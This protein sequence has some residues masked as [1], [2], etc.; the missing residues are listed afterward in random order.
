M[1]E[2]WAD[3]GA[4]AYLAAAAWAFFEGETFV[5]LASAAGHATGLIDPWILMVSVWIGS[6]LGDQL[7]FTL[8]QRYGMRAVRKIPGAEKRMAAALRFLDRY[9]TLFVLSFRFVYGVRNVASA[10]C[11][12]AG[13][14]RIRFAT[15]NFIAAGLWAASFVAAGW[16]LVAWLGERNTSYA[17]AGIGGAVV[18]YLI[19]RFIQHR[20][21]KA[22]AQ[23]Q[24]HGSPQAP[25]H[26]PAEPHPQPV[27]QGPASAPPAPEKGHTFS[28]VAV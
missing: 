5:I 4:L 7:W 24:A 2:F 11:G 18:L 22:Q 23:L 28:R 16:F 15:L 10:A 9:G 3:W 21:R 1:A 19:F 17:L 12:I 27:P 8:G 6:F 26:A 25:V 20:R 14:K 13:M